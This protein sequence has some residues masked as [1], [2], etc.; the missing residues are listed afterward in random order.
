MAIT[1]V[2]DSEISRSYD[3]QGFGQCEMLPGSYD[4]GKFYKCFV[5][6]GSTVQPKLCRD[7]LAVYCFVK[8]TGYVV[9]DQRTFNIDE[10]CF[11][12]PGFELAKME[13]HAN[14][15][16]EY[17]CLVMDMTEKDWAQ[18]NKNHT[19]LPHFVTISSARRYEQDCS[20][21]GTQCFSIFSTKHVVRI[22]IGVIINDQGGTETRGNIEKG[23]PKVHQWN[24]CLPGAN[25]IMDVEGEQVECHEG[26]WNFVP[27]GLDHSLIGNKPEHKV[28]YFW[29]EHFVQEFE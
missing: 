7:K 26:D 4:L 13:I 10:L 28:R 24:Y 1:M 6:A 16:M 29:F 2:R 8:G 21:Q 23:H 5:K 19:Y 9:T 17:L 14:E 3:A 20:T 11:L 15:D 22:M 27:A 25:F 18:Y 12:V